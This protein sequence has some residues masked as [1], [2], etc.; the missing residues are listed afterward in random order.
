M[1]E[2]SQNVKGPAR[3]ARARAR[4]RRPPAGNR[5][6]AAEDLLALARRR[7]LAR[8]RIRLEELAGELG[9]ARATAYRWFGNAEQ[10]AGQ[11][12]CGLVDETF[13]RTLREGRGRGA[14]RIVD[15]TA[16]GLRYIAGN[17]AYRAFVASDPQKALRIVA[18]KEGPVQARTI[19]HH[20]ALLREEIE[21]GQLRL[22]VDPH[23]MAYALVRVA[24]SF[25]YAD[26]IA[27]EKPDLDKAVEIIRLMLRSAE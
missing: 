8:E 13:A 24:E 22:P 16:R 27:G 21:R 23:T 2:T 14:Q 4:R 5:P 26:V 9:V 17:A 19:A 12:I 11:V 6:S 7:F 10:L 18:S 15:V 3:G 20:E 25:L 1:S